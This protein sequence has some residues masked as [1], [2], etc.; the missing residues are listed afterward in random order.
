MR[1]NNI[2]AVLVAMLMATTT[3]KAA[4]LDLTLSSVTTNESIR[5]LTPTTRND[6]TC[7][8]LNMY[9][10]ARGSTYEDI[11]A[12]GLSTRNRVTHY[13]KTY[14]QI[15]WERGQ[16][17]WTTRDISGIIPKEKAT[18]HRLLKIAHEVVDNQHEDFTNGAT[19]FYSAKLA[20]PPRWARNRN[21]MRIGAHF[22][23]RVV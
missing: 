2:A 13:K 19:S 5:S 18:W 7:L 20:S 23:V 14:C 1:Y 11:L 4:S 21:A 9:H 6:V 8:A 22:Y 17:V 12:V 16:Y 15:I 10:E 3:A